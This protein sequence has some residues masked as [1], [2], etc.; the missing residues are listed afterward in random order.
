MD[1]LQG[2]VPEEKKSPWK[3]AIKRFARKGLIL[4]AVMFVVEVILFFGVSSLPFLPGEKTAY[5][6]Q[7]SQLSSQ[8]QNASLPTTFWGIFSNNYRIALL[9]FIPLFGPFLFAFSLYATARILEVEAI[10]YGLPAAILGISLFLLP[11]SWLELPAYGVATAEGLLLVYAAVKWIF[12]PKARG[13]ISA[14]AEGAQFVLYLAIVTV[15]LLIAALFEASEIALGEAY[16]NSPGL[17][18]LTW[19]PFAVILVVALKLYSHLR[20]IGNEPDTSVQP[21]T[22]YPPQNPPQYPP[23]TPPAPQQNPQQNTS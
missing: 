18:F 14:S 10:T 16:P 5:Q 12:I 8:F 1:H 21:V 19:I 13:T 20:K 17:P 2:M 7:S 23:Q 3:T 15:M 9:E 11:H 4:C 6:S 22:Q